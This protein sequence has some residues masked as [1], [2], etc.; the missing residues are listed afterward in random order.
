MQ[1]VC[2]DDI[3]NSVVCKFP[4]GA[5]AE[6]VLDCIG[7]VLG[8]RGEEIC[9][10]DESLRLVVARCVAVQGLKTVTKMSVED[11]GRILRRSEKTVARLDEEYATLTPFLQLPMCP[12]SGKEKIEYLLEKFKIGAS[13]EDI[14]RGAAETYGVAAELILNGRRR[15]RHISCAR[16]AVMYVLRTNLGLSLQDIGNCFNGGSAHVSHTAVR[17]SL[18]RVDA[19]LRQDDVDVGESGSS[20]ALGNDAGKLA[21]AYTRLGLVEHVDELLHRHRLAVDEVVPELARLVG[22]R[23]EDVMSSRKTIYA[24][25]RAAAVVVLRERFPG[26]SLESCGAEFGNK[27]HSTVLYYLQELIV[28]GLYTPKVELPPVQQVASLNNV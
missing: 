11:I 27:H 10:I 7:N 17:L 8:V 25:V 12:F 26:M 24:A 22:L 4:K 9:G 15:R 14:I 1:E 3:V 19:V 6:A 21:Q 5:T 28:A 16:A 18:A 20:S 2:L 13:P 23:R